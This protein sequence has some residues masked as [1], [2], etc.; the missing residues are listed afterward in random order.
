MV[1]NNVRSGH[2]CAQTPPLSTRLTA[3]PIWDKIKKL[4]K[5]PVFMK[6]SGFHERAPARN[7]NPYVFHCF[8]RNLCGITDFMRSK[9][10]VVHHDISFIHTSII[11]LLVAKQS[12][13]NCWKS[14]EV[15]NHLMV[16][17]R[18]SLKLDEG[19]GAR[20]QMCVSYIGNGRMN[21]C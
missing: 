6:I 12:E 20:R 11:Y 4:W 15:R 18:D 21:K 14:V 1:K 17:Y 10:A 19:C 8:E 13:Q 16:G 2:H 7:C 5:L 9:N 3:R